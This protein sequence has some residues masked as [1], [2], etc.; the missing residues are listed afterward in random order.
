LPFVAQP[1]PLPGVV[2]VSPT[3]HDD[4]RGTFFEMYKRS[5]Y[6]EF[7]IDR[8]F[9][10]DNFSHSVANVVRGLH[11]Q[12]PPAAQAKLVSVVQGRILDAIVDI[13]RGSPGYGKW[14]SVELSEQNR[15]SLF[16]P[17]GYAH[18]FCVLSEEADVM[19]KCSAEFDPATE[20]G[21]C[22]N[23]P[24]VGIAWPVEKPVISVRDAALPT[25]SNLVNNFVY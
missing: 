7:G 20:G 22:W 10:Q 5:E 23:D 8:D 4:S 21:I 18:G 6:R 12:F 15:K 3:L 13:R 16:V 17:E 14:F 19:Y 25:L 11:F 1:G 2:V 24:D 9:V